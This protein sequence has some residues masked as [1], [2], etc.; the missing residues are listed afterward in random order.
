MEGTPAL[1]VTTAAR[2]TVPIQYTEAVTFTAVCR[3][4]SR[5]EIRIHAMAANMDSTTS[6]S[7]HMLLGAPPDA[8]SVDSAIKPAPIVEDASASQPPKCNCS[9]KN[10]TAA[11]ARS[12]GRVP[13]IREACET[14]VRESSFELDKILGWHPEYRCGENL[15]PFFPIEPRMIKEDN[16]KQ[17]GGHG[18][19]REPKQNHGGDWHFG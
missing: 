14:V 8:F 19:E 7:P 10:N 18:R 13:T 3:R 2:S 11:M 9:P 5:F 16:R 12:M 1:V 15:A 17:Y 6:R 4:M